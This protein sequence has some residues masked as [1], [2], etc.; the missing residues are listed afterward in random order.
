[1]FSDCYSCESQYNEV[2]D[3]DEPC[4]V[5]V[6]ASIISNMYI[7]VCVCSAALYIYVQVNVGERQAI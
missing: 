1:M 4:Y 7:Y 6:N 5:K 2:T 3:L